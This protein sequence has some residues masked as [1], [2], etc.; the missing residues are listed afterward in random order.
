M[1]TIKINNKQYPGGYLFDVDKELFME[2]IEKHLG[3]RFGQPVEVINIYQAF[4]GSDIM[5][6]EA[7]LRE[8]DNSADEQ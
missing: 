8:G 5:K 6:V 3:E 1:G 4:L 2:W 7:I